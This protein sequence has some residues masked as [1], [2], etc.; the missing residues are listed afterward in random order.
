MKMLIACALFAAACALPAL[1]QN[2]ALS[3]SQ[4]AR[5]Q[6]SDEQVRVERRAYRAQC[7]RYQSVDYCECMTGGMAQSLA[8]RDLHTAAALL[9]HDL[10]HAPMPKR[11]DHASVAAA[12]AATAEYEPGCAQY[13][14]R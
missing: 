2:G 9:A 11:L 12:R 10:G 1:A 5:T 4:D 3:Y 6:G 7:E 14:R 8:P 13:R